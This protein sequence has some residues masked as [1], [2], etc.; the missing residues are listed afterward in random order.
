MNKI[1]V[2]RYEL[3]KLH[4][5]AFAVVTYEATFFTFEVLK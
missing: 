1:N 5:V 4:Y 2:G 3:M